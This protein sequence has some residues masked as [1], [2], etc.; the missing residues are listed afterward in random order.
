MNRAEC[1]EL[2]R[3][4]G[5]NSDVIAHSIAVADLA[6]EICDIRWKDLA[7]RELVE[8]G[9]LLHDIGRSK[10]QQIDHAV[11]GVEIGRELG[12]D[13]RILLII[14][15]HIGAGITQDEAEALGLPAKDYL[16]ET[17]EE[18]IVAHADNLVDDTT[19]ITFHER[20]KQVEERLTEAHVN[21]MIKLHNEVCGRR[22]EPEIFCGYAKINDV[23]Q[24]MKEI[25]DI[26][27]KHSLVIQIVDGD[28]VAG[29]EH[30]RSAVFKAIRSMDAGEAIASSLSLEILLYLAGTR[31]ISKALEIGVKEGEGRVCL[32]I[33]GDE[34]GKDVK[35]EIFELL[36]F[37]ED[38]FSRSCENKEQLMAFFGITEEEL[39]VAGEDKLEML[40]IERGALLEVLK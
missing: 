5:C 10:T 35:E 28:L 16:P 36:H 31:N 7:D 15:R 12:L 26:A 22:F 19:R 9:A 29:K 24:L 2:L 1:I 21:R 30:V 17:I 14:E 3:Q 27:Q 4:T 18:K 25:T 32:I 33:I 11:I 37:K 20:I 6:L 13:P 40:V 23:K 8:A 38:D 34:V 39:G